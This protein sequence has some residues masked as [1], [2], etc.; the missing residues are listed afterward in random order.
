[1]HGVLGLC[2]DTENP[3]VKAWL[4]AWGAQEN[5]VAAWR[6]NA[7][8]RDRFLLGK[9]VLPTSLVHCLREKCGPTLAKRSVHLF[10]KCALSLL[11]AVLTRWSPEE[12]MSFKQRLN[13]YVPDG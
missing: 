8:A 9:M 13:P 12:R 1:M 6:R 10:Q 5:V 3:L 11:D 2:P 4:K 7:C